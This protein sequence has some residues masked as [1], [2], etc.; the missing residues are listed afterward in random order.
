M[1]FKIFGR[2]GCATAPTSGGR[3]APS[4]RRFKKR[5]SGWNF[6]LFSIWKR[7][8]W[9]L[10][11]VWGARMKFSIDF[12][13][14]RMEFRSQN[15]KIY[16][17]GAKK[18][19]SK[20][21]PSTTGRRNGWWWISQ[22][23]LKITLSEGSCEFP[24]TASLLFDELPYSPF[25]FQKLLFSRSF[26]GGPLEKYF[27]RIGWYGDVDEEAPAPPSELPPPPPEDEDTPEPPPDDDQKLVSLEDLLHLFSF[28][29]DRSS[30]GLFSFRTGFSSGYWLCFWC[31]RWSS[32]GQTATPSR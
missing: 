7:Y 4:T 19:F 2:R 28:I 27:L 32:G 25:F 11:T 9:S 24:R 17:E 26:L 15:P 3:P 1:S 13:Y 8:F 12:W 21:L 5:F 14:V 22:I 18:R 31:I 20:R 6:S 16:F 10:W 29:V 23:Y 30:G